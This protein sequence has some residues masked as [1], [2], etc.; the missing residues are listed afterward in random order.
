MSIRHVVMWKMNGADA[1]ERAAILNKVADV[2]DANRELLAVAVDALEVG[3]AGDDVRHH[4]ARAVTRRADEAGGGGRNAFDGL[5]A[6]AGFFH[7][8]AWGEV[9]GHGGFL[10]CI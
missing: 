1:A 5:R 8:D 10:L 4:R 3:Q 9:F 7:I 2:I 6:E